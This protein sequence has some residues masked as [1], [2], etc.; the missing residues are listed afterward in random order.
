M[1]WSII[2]LVSVSVEY[3]VIRLKNMMIIDCI[4]AR[5][6]VYEIKDLTLSKSDSK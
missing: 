6:T 5:L 3:H 4:A 1:E 2:S